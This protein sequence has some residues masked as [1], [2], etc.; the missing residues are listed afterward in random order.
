[1][2]LFRELVLDEGVEEFMVDGLVPG[3]AG[4]R[5]A[6]VCAALMHDI[7]KADYGGA[8]LYGW[9]LSWVS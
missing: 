3:L 2:L 9:G 6:E 1:M 7:L 4:E 5:C 8:I